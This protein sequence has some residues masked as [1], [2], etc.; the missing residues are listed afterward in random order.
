MLLEWKS[1]HRLSAPQKRNG[2]TNRGISTLGVSRY[3]VKSEA[4]LS[5]PGMLTTVIQ[6]KGLL[7]NLYAWAWMQ[8]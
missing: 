2:Q 4:A 1:V 7:F 3:T 8:T 6:A 5:R